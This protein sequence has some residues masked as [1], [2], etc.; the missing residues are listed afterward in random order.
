MRGSHAAGDDVAAIGITNQ[1]ETTVAIDRADG[2]R[3]RARDR[4]AGP[5]HRC[6]VRGA[7]RRRPRA[8]CSARAPAS[9]CDPYFSATKMRWLLDHGVARRRA[10]HSGCARSTRSCCWHLTGGADGGVVRHRRVERLAHHA[11]R[12]RRRARGATSCAR[13]SACRRG[14][15]AELAPVVRRRSGTSPTT[16]SRA[17]TASP[18]AGILGDQQAALF[19]QRCTSPGMVKATFGTG[20]FLLANAGDGA[21]SATSTASSRPSRGT[22]ASTGG[23]TFAARGLRVR[24][25]R[26]DPVAPRRARPRRA[27][28]RR[29]AAW[30]RASTDANGAMLR[31]RARRS[32]E[33][34]VGP[35]R[36]RRARWASRAGVTRAHVARAV[37]DALGVPGPRDARRDARRRRRRSP[38]CASTAAPRRWTCCASSLADGARGSRAPTGSV[39][40]TAIGAATDRGCRRRRACTLEG[41]RRRRGRTRRVRARGDADVRRP[42]LRGLA[43]RGRARPGAR[44]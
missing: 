28:R 3:P 13:C 20:A 31:P 14:A 15:L 1:R 22:S 5:P 25:G 19:G 29:P 24:R 41:S 9:P 32:R 2:A 23:R 37:V 8:R 38:S 12:P 40:A 16:S 27:R 26:G 11:L 43:R 21:A 39:E 7:R 18:I 30:P 4:L 42:R 33:P 44:R 34:V 35:R 6:R 10:R 17:S 36:A